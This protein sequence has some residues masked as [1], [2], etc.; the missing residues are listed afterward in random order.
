VLI[1]GARDHTAYPKKDLGQLEF[2]L[3]GPDAVDWEAV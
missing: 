2:G 1:A 3:F